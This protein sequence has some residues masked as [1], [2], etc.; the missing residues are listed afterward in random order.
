MERG[1]EDDGVEL[2]ILKRQMCKLCPEARK[3]SRQMP[4]I[5]FGRSQA[6][7]LIGEQ[8]HGEGMVSGNR[9]AKTHPA[10]SRAEVQ[11]PSTPCGKFGF[12]TCSI[13]QS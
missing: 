1:I 9:Q 2:L 12:S 13:K 7:G 5:V 11:N 3:K 8:I 4:S 6:I 10:V